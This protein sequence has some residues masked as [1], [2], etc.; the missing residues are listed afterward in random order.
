VGSAVPQRASAA[1]YSR[2]VHFFFNSFF[3]VFL[4]ARGREPG[5][6]E[7]GPPPP[8]KK[9]KDGRTHLRENTVGRIH[10]TPE[11]GQGEEGAFEDEMDKRVERLFGIVLS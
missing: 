6:R 2:P 5:R 8:L 11:S 4:C 10:G 1:A 3:F 7:I 9:I